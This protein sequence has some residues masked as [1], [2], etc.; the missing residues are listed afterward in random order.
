MSVKLWSVGGIHPTEG[1]LAYAAFGCFRSQEDAEKFQQACWK[2]WGHRWQFN[3]VM[4]T[5]SDEMPDLPPVD[6]FIR[7]YI[8]FDTQEGP[9]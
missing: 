7:R 6:E 1:S 2:T 9:A 4:E 8:D 5:A 3:D